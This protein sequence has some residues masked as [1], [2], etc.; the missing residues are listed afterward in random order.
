[1]T[2]ASIMVSLDLGA[3][4]AAR[5][6]LAASLTER[7]EAT[8]TGV[9]ARKIPNPGPGEDLETIQEA[10]KKE[11]A[12]LSEELTRCQGI[13]EQSCGTEI[14][15]IWRQAEADATSFLVRQALAADIVVVGRE[16]DDTPETRPPHPALC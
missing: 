3:M 13:F 9:A 8:L 15:R 12:K 10:Y 6:R 1:M 4:A 7:F 5:V 14:R 2:I 11:Q 16:K